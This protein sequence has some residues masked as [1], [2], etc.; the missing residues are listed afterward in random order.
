MANEHRRNR[1]NTVKSTGV[2]EHG[3]WKDSAV[4]KIKCVV[5]LGCSH[6]AFKTLILK[7]L[8]GARRPSKISMYKRCTNDNKLHK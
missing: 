7:T 4:S 5:D 2:A 8:L 6:C 3:F 1:Q